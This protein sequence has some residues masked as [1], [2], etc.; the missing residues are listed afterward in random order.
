MV[1]SHHVI[2]GE[3]NSGPLEEQS[4]LLATEPSLQPERVSYFVRQSFPFILI[5]YAT[6]YDI[7]TVMM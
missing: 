4:V 5:T 3:L 1:V 7:F 6:S 2:A